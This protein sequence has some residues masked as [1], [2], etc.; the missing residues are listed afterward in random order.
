MMSFVSRYRPGFTG[1]ATLGVLVWPMLPFVSACGQGAKAASVDR[2][3]MA[4]TYAAKI[5][6]ELDGIGDGM[7]STPF[8]D[9]AKTL[10][11][12]TSP[13]SRKPVPTDARGWPM[14]DAQ[15]VLFD[16]RPFPAWNPPIDD[17]SR[18]Q[19]DWS[20]TYHLAFH[21]QAEMRCREEPTS[22]IA[23][24][25]YDPASNT[26]TADVVVPKGAGLLILAF[27]HTRRSPTHPPDSGIT[28]LKVMRPGYPADTCDVFTREFLRSLT[29]FAV[30]R[31]MDWLDTNHQPGYYGDA[32]HHAL[33]WKDRRLPTDSTQ[34]TTGEKYGAAWEYV[35]QLAN[36]TGKDLWINIPVAATDDYVRQLAARLKRDLKPKLR[37]YIEHSNEVWNFGF[38]QYTYNKLAAIEE[39]S[40]GGSKLNN[41]G[42]MDQEVWA[43]R[44]H[45]Q[46]LIQIGRIFRRIFGEAGSLDRIRPVY[47][48]WVINPN[49]YYTAVLG[50]VEKTYGPPNQFFYGVAGAAYFNADK[51]GPMAS[52]DQVLAAMRASS[53]ENRTWRTQIQKI[54]ERYGLKHC[55][56]E[57]G[58]DT[59]G[60]KT[61]NV[62]NRILANRDPRIK[63]I[64]LHDATQNWFSAG[65]DLYMYF[66][67]CS[68]YSRY[69]CWGLSEDI[70]NLSTPKW[71]AIHA[72]S[73]VHP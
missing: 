61:E 16:I 36:T 25:R 20:G 32:S 62:A 52:V 64:I 46:R 51:A 5:G 23:H 13:D 69:G 71:R 41:D 60:G 59:G 54:A 68:S 70:A 35:A 42:S 30:L 22:A 63:D 37:I 67:H 45:A 55:Q 7:R 33:N 17:P 53:D 34:Q 28:D 1:V 49:D 3:R 44:R 43:H 58:P 29:P 56:Y 10:R 21:G 31:Y 24:A 19:P 14:A 26:T 18:F 15:T 50:W 66:S 8:I 2:P 40:H 4:K 6:V 73:S 9:V 57:V 72:L 38:P 48:S 27:V 39:A 47:A 65:G 12:W 11:P